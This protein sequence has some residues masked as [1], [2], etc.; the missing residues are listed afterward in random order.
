MRALDD[1]EL[2]KAL[3]L[4]E[5]IACAKS[6]SRPHWLV[7]QYIEDQSLCVFH[8]EPRSFKTFAALQLA[9]ATAVGASWLGQKVNRQ[10]ESLYVGEE[11]AASMLAARLE[12]LSPGV[13]GDA[14]RVLHRQGIAT[15][16]RE[17][18]AFVEAA[19]EGMTSPALVIFDTYSDILDGD[20]NSAEDQREAIRLI[21]RLI[22]DYHVTA[23]VIHHDSKNAKGRRP[24]SRIR[25]SGKLW[26]SSDST[27]SFTRRPGRPN[28]RPGGRIAVETKDSDQ[29]SFGF[30]W[31]PRTFLLSRVGNTGT[32]RHSA[33]LAAFDG[34]VGP[35][36]SL[37]ATD[38]RGMTGI[39]RSV[40]GDTLKELVSAEMLAVT[41]SG[42]S[43]RYQLVSPARRVLAA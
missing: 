14:V 15:N 30:E 4:S 12:R 39:G 17:S 22:T 16:D 40:L 43:T 20:E 7:D 27:L 9:C 32:G 41:G 33:V 23:L 38:I 19:I 36:G 10:G 31:D 26:G 24:G 28:V 21:Q 5:F 37:S 11:G 35:D 42:P 25:G 8:G 3:T 2:G 1:R 29:T 34:D 6:N 13:P 18:W